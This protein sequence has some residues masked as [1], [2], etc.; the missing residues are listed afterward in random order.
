MAPPSPYVLIVDETP[1]RPPL[2]ELPITQSPCSVY[3]ASSPE[4]AIAQ[5]QEALPCLVILVGHDHTWVAQQLQR[6]RRSP[7]T[8]EMPIMA[9]T[10]APW[11]TWEPQA[12]RPDVDGFLVKPLTPDV[13][14]SLVASALVQQAF[15]R[16]PLTPAVRVS[17]GISLER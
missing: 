13:L 5:A 9:L 6:L 17:R 2:R 14:H 12:N 16:S 3:V 4:Q 10:E 1:H 8:L 7:Q 11:P 15:R